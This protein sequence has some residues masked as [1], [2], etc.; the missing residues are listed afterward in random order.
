M[1]KPFPRFFRRILLAATVVALAACGSE[2]ADA[3]ISSPRDAIAAALANPARS[4][5]EMADDVLRKPAEVLAFTGI[6]PGMNIFEMEA[7]HG[8]YTEILAHIVGP[9]GSI[10][11]Q[12][13]PAF[14]S[15]AGAAVK[16]RLSGNRLPNVRHERCDF[17][18]L[19][20]DDGSIDIVTWFLGPH[21]LY[22]MPAGVDNLGDEMRAYAEIMRVLKPGGYFV[23]LDH[24]APP[25]SPKSTG[26]DTHRIDPA[27][28]K[29]LA[30][31]AGFELVDQNDLL[32][33]TTDNYE[34]GV[35]HP[36]VRRKTDRFLMKFKKPEERPS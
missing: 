19:L 9:T 18:K 14:D 33:N 12:N 16:K 26:A 13:P 8:Y 29:G 20:A 17:D 21:E 11:M 30:E 23:V 32:R 2:P 36:E 4:A 34:L 5:D 25:G 3:P 31:E 7:G 10:I 6:E 15:F 1:T 27:I 24:A 22:F 35:F 28:V